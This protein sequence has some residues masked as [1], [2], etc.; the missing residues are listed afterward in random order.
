MKELDALANKVL[1]LF[2]KPKKGQRLNMLLEAQR[3]F[4]VDPSMSKAMKLRTAI[5]TEME[6][7]ARGK[8][9]HV[10]LRLLNHIGS[11]KQ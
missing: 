1:D 4:H 3:K 11:F 9:Y 5:F 2:D 10:L 6:T 8:K 7:Y